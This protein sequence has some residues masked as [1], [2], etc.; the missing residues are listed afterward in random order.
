[1]PVRA[2][3]EALAGMPGI[4]Y[5]EPDYV[6][7][8][9][10]VPDDPYFA[11]LWGMATIGAAAAWDTLVGDSGCVVAVIDSGVDYNHPD[12]AANVWENADEIA[13]NGL[14]D[15]GNGFVDD[16]RGWD[17]AYGDNDPFDGKGHG[18]HVAGTIAGAGNNGIGV[19]GVS[20]NVRVMPVK[21]LDDNGS[22]L[23]SAAIE[24]IEYAVANGARISNNSW[25]G[26]GYSQ[27][28][29]DAL[30][31]AREQGHLFVAA[32]G[33]GGS[34]Y[35]GDNTDITPFYPASYGLDNIIA[36]AAINS[37]DAKPTFSN[38]G[39]SS[40]DLGA[41]GVGVLSTY[42]GERYA[43]A[44]GTSMAAPHVS[45]VA[46]LVSA[47]HPEWDQPGDFLK[48]RDQILLNTRPIASLSG[49]TVTGGTLDADGAVNHPVFP[50]DTPAGLTAT[51]VSSTQVNVAWADTTTEWAYQV[52]RSL[53]GGGTW[54]Q[55]GATGLNRT[56]YNDSGLSAGATPC[57]RVQAGNSFG[58]SA[59]SAIAD[60]ET[61]GATPTMH[62]QSIG[63]TLSGKNSIT[64]TAAVKIHNA[65]D[66]PVASARVAGTWTIAIPGKTPTTA[67]ATATTGSTGIASLRSPTKVAPVG[68]VF[69]FTVTGVTH[70][71][72]VY[73]ASASHVTSA[74]KT[75]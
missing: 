28:L 56:T 10:A 5:A 65:S 19:V 12:L 21:F 45:G 59:F 25:G 41:P 33:N 11:D 63:I 37:A 24:A 42:P 16:V 44:D 26:G 67:T 22:G 1:M 39:A 7:E 20:W 3:L 30:V 53:D 62:V 70:A 47:L 60:A 71:S 50:L 14:D 61:P 49:K 72:Y 8:A 55:I 66:V 35:Y 58:V 13:D 54:A 73:D 17:F 15:D 29:Y 74:S 18:T 34:D 9:V 51:P 36:V 57:Y 2:A 68:T 38:Y 52:F 23:T 48:V 4:E 64:A 46:A 40:V 27:A 31:A 43:Y 6:V 75:R 32:A 69:T